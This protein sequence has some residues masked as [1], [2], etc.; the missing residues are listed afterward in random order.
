MV[1][2]IV[3]VIF[4]LH[5][6]IHLFGFVAFLKIVETKDIQYRT[7]IF[8]GKVDVGDFGIK[9]VGIL[10]LLA[11]VGFVI[12][13]VGV[14]GLSDWWQSVTLYVTIFSLI[15]TITG[16]PDSV[17][18]AVTNIIILAYLFLAPK[19]SFLPWPE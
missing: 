2:I 9:I 7:T 14:F 10:W 5:G 11:A 4:A 18:G 6:L 12:A 17:F 3:S 19:L 1:R 16:I 15:I 13:A 8:A